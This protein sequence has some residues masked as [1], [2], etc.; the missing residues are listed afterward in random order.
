MHTALQMPAKAPNSQ[1]KDHLHSWR[2]RHGS[3]QRIKSPI[4][5]HVRHAKAKAITLLESGQLPGG[6]TA[7]VQVSTRTTARKCCLLEENVP[8]RE[9]GCA[10]PA[11][12]VIPLPPSACTSQDA[13][14]G[15]VCCSWLL[16]CAWG[17]AHGPAVLPV[18]DTGYTMLSNCLRQRIVCSGFGAAK[19]FPMPRGPSQVAMRLANSQ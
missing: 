9:C 7:D 5:S 13:G 18:N 14:D 19:S 16:D 4:I 15:P 17:C 6:L 10:P 1:A 12:G 3:M 8:G 2:M 11:W